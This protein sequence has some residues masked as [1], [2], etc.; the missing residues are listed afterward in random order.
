MVW[1][2]ADPIVTAFCFILTKYEMIAGIGA[3]RAILK[4][5][6]FSALRNIS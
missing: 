3:V 2:A 1:E 4:K 5:Y 6:V